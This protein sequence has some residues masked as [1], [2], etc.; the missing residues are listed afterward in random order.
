[1]LTLPDGGA[2][3]QLSTSDDG[4]RK[5]GFIFWADRFCAVKHGACKKFC[6]KVL[7]KHPSKKTKEKQ[8]PIFPRKKQAQLLACFLE[9]EKQPYPLIQL[10]KPT[11]I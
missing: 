5:F 1:M 4:A 2:R 9:L 3:I 11:F 6:K 8:S 7:H 10:I